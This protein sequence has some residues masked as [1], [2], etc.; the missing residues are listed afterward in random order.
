MR[1]ILLLLGVLI[2]T[3]GLCV[4]T[5]SATLHTIVD[6]DETYIE[7]VDETGS[8][9]FKI[10]DDDGVTITGT[11]TVSGDLLFS[12]T[13]KIMFHDSDQY[14]YAPADGQLGILTDGVFTVDATTS[15]TITA[16]ISAIDASTSHTVT[17]PATAIVATTSFTVTSPSVLQKKSAVDYVTTAVPDSGAVTVTVTGS[18]SG[19]Y[20]IVTDDAGI[21]LDAFDTVSVEAGAG[22]FGFSA[23]TLD[24]NALTIT[25]VGDII[26]TNAAGPTMQNEAATNTNPT[27]I[28]NRNEEDTGIGWQSDVIHIV[29]GTAD[30]YSFS[31]STLDM[32]TNTITEAGN[33]FANTA[34]GAALVDEASVS[35]NP[36]LCPDR[37]Q[38][39]T[40]VGS[41][42]SILHLIIGGTDEVS[43]SAT[44]VTLPS[45]ELILTSGD[46]TFTGNLVQ[47]DNALAYVTTTVSDSGAV[48]VDVTGD[49]T[50]GSYEIETD[51]VGI[52]L[53]AANNITLDAGTGDV[54]IIT[55]V[56]VAHS[57]KLQ[58][59]DTA[60]YIN[61]TDSNDL[62]VVAGATLIMTSPIIRFDAA[63]SVIHRDNAL[64]YVTTTV[65]DSGAVVVSV[66][67]DSTLGSYEII[68]DDL[69]I[70]LDAKTT[71]G[72]EVDGTS[73][74]SFSSGTLDMNSNT[75]TEVGGVV[76]DDDA[77]VAFGDDSDIS[78]DFD[79]TRTAL[80]ILPLGNFVSSE[81]MS[82]R[83]RLEWVAGEQ[84]K[85]GLHANIRS[86]DSAV[87]AATDPL[88]EI[89]GTNASS[90]D[91]ISYAEGGIAIT[92]DGADG[93]EVILLPHLDTSVSAW[94]HVIWGTDNEV[95]WETYIRTTAS[96]DSCIIWAGL[97]LTNTEVMTTDDDQ[98]YFRYENLVNGGEWQ[99]IT[100]VNAGADDAHDTNVA[101]AAT[102]KYHLVIEIDNAGEAKFYIDGALVETGTSFTGEH[103]DLK[104]YIGVAGDGTSPTA[105][106]I[107]VRGQVIS[108]EYD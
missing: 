72:I 76:V 59:L 13:D 3:L 78:L 89:L 26:T 80:V 82:D 77:T 68:T 96:I 18:G 62:A 85:P 98:L 84:G 36:T 71:V 1:K 9:I 47:K 48:K 94:E 99:A 25:D 33:I 69:T 67:G 34:T 41:G 28:P 105:R 73:E 54:D 32:N 35:G 66:T 46:I 39:S 87:V 49:S 20:E 63:T 40:G 107:V 102:T 7:W 58:F 31:T 86:A 60:T 15:S 91:V 11:Y 17:S 2:L 45:N 6:D 52:V 16:P 56:L 92:T 5:V 50:L 10:D 30:E 43:V 51:G 27:L 57:E 23:T 64:A 95:R 106:S 97:K 37:N 44:A 83:F 103:A 79:S 75:L 14:V 29:L 101:V 61:A 81:G 55:D 53:D 65:S 108:R 100:T 24:M 21:I 104:P 4:G 42:A 19:S 88:F 12:G 93:D 90:D 8:S 74:Y 38:L 70:T 22:T